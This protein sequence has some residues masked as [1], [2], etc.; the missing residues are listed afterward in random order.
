MQL[1]LRRNRILIHGLFRISP[2]KKVD[3]KCVSSSKYL[4]LSLLPAPRAKNTL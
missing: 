2:A 4:F 1:T 3:Q